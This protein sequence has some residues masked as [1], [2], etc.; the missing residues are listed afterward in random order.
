M[1]TLGIV[2]CSDYPEFQKDEQLL[3]PALEALD[4]LTR[5]IIWE[6]A[7]AGN[8]DLQTI[9]LLVFRSCWNYH[10]HADAFATWLNQ[11]EAQHIPVMNPVPLIRWNLDKRYLQFLEAAG[12][13]IV[14]TLFT[15]AGDHDWPEKTRQTP[16]SEW[17]IKPVVSAWGANTYRLRR[18]ELADYIEKLNPHAQETGLMIQPFVPE[19]AAGEWSL[20]YYRYRGE[21]VFSH[22]FLKQ[23]AAGAFLSHEEFGA[24]WTPVEASSALRK[25]AQKALAVLPTDWLYARVDGVQVEGA[26]WLMELEVFEPSLYLAADLEAPGRLARVLQAALNAR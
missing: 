1:K 12:V 22:A 5:P 14:P 25:A 18:A 7:A 16:W 15:A 3:A 26:L 4:I 8:I 19:I 9:D 21:T 13:P 11:L 2:T 6:Q 24:R 20:V 23:P 17:V 10:Y